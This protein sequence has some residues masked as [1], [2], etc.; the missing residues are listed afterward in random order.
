MCGGVRSDAARGA[1]LIHAPFSKSGYGPTLPAAAVAIKCQGC[2]A[3]E[4]SQGTVDA[5]I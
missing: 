3:E 4:G 2:C 1:V 5:G